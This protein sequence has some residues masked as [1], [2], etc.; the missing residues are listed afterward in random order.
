MHLVIFQVDHL[1]CECG[2]RAVDLLQPLYGEG[3][4]VLTVLSE[5]KT[6]VLHN[7]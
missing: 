2:L 5:A 1:L 7:K 6:A 4:R 3:G